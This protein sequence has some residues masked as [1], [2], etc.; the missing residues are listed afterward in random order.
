MLKRRIHGVAAE[1]AAR[2][3]AAFAAMRPPPPP[4]YTSH[5]CWAARGDAGGVLPD[6]VASSSARKADV[7]YVHPTSYFGEQWNACWDDAGAAVQVDELQLKTQTA[8]FAGV[9]RV[10]APRYRQMTYMGFVSTDTDSARAAAE[11]AYS[12]VE[13]AFEVFLERHNDG[14]PI[15]LAS[16]S[17]GTLHAARL[18]QQRVDGDRELASRCVAAYLLGMY[19]P[20]SAADQLQCFA[21]SASPE[22]PH[23][24]I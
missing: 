7:F 1:L 6:G 20:T 9:C 14:R 12:D 24:L 3:P 2:P 5:Q 23:A 8:P 10:F 13:R 22:Q 17:Q 11:L 4:D 19:I 16:H 15:F 21:P 18:L